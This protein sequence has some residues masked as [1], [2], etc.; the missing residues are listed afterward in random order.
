[1]PG[2]R[3]GNRYQG[4][5]GETGAWDVRGRQ[6]PQM[7]GEIGT[8]DGMGGKRVGDGYL[9]CKD[10]QLRGSYANQFDSLLIAGQ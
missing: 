9:G 2:V 8:R 7:R 4:L 6:I 5:E 10:L 1:M 3:E